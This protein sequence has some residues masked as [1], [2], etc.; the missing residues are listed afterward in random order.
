MNANSFTVLSLTYEIKTNKPTITDVRYIVSF[1]LISPE[2]SNDDI[3]SL[4]Y[5]E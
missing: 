2:K 5:V 1:F 4:L 3:L